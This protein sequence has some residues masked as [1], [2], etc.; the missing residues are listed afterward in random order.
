MFCFFLSCNIFSFFSSQLSLYFLRKR[1]FFSCEFVLLHQMRW[2]CSQNKFVCF[3]VCI[4]ERPV[5]LYL[6]NEAAETLTA[7][8]RT[9]EWFC[10]WQ[11]PRTSQES[12]L[13]VDHMDSNWT[14]SVCNH[15][16]APGTLWVLESRVC[17]TTR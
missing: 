13:F 4:W 11:T 15:I 2:I 3:F 8:W 9:E 16:A 5:T 17:E 14:F 12:L 1:N 7:A 10:S 6:G